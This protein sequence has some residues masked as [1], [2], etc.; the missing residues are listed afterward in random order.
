MSKKDR[1]KDFS[2]KK[3]YG[4]GFLAGLVVLV[5]VIA[6]VFGISHRKEESVDM[7]SNTWK[8]LLPDSCSHVEEASID[9]KENLSIK[10]LGSYSGAYLEDGSDEEV[11]DVMMMVITNT[12]EEALQYAEITLSNVENDGEDM[13]F[14]IST[15]GPGESVMVLEAERRTYPED[16]IE[17][18]TEASAANVVFFSEGMQLYEDQLKIQSLDGGCNITNISK[19]D[20]KGDLVIYFKNYGEEMLYGGITYRGRIEGGLK[21]GEIRQIM[22]EHFSET[23]TKV[24]FITIAEE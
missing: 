15:L 16:H 23:G 12:G 20:I 14:K 7:E 19:E 13:L 24:M 9:M 18:Y 2:E 21:A 6:V 5:L 17:E 22:S 8:K 11:S 1:K 10:A 3:K 4:K